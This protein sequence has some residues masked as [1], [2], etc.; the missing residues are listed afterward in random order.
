MISIKSILKLISTSKMQKLAA[1]VVNT[2]QQ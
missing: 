2:G 1:D